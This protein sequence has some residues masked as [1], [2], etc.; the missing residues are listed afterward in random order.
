MISDQP[1]FPARLA[2]RELPFVPN[3]FADAH[4][5]PFFYLP[6]EASGGGVCD[7]VGVGGRG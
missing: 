4:Q 3:L 2:N 7:G 6:G 1:C 5:K